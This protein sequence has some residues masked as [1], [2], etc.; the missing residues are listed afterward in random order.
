MKNEKN[1]LPAWLRR[2]IPDLLDTQSVGRILSE[3]GLN[4]VCRSARCPNRAECFKKGTATF[5][6]LGSICTRNCRFCNI[7]PGE[8][9]EADPEEPKR[10]AAAA[11]AMKLKYAVVTSVTRDDLPD[12]GAGFFAE[13]VLLLHQG[14]IK[15]EIL[16]PDFEGKE[17]SLKIVASA[18]PDVFN[19]NLETVPRLYS[20]ARPQADYRRSLEVLRMFK[21]LAPSIPTKSGLM[22]GLGEE[23]EEVIRV[24]EDLVENH[25]DRLTLGQY[26]PPSREHLPVF[27]YLPPEEFEEWGELAR[28]AGFK[29]VFSGPLVRSS[30]QAETAFE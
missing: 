24:F 10:V 17:A 5:L 15:V 22:L 20:E 16:T 19:H 25:C 28:K 18:S 26:I 23:R 8:P 2:N 4:T 6:I 7:S 27:R 30:Y 29:Q 3:G 1:R 14:G 9:L 11:I 21:E 12:G 13:T